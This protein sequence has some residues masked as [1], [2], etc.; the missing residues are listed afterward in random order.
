MADILSAGR[1]TMYLVNS[2]LTKRYAL[3][4]GAG[5]NLFQTN[6]KWAILFTGYTIT[7]QEI[8]SKSACLEDKRVMYSFGKGFG[9]ISITGEALLGNSKSKANFESTLKEFYESNRLS[10]NPVPLKLS[11]IGT[12]VFEFYLV[13]VNVAGYNSNYEILPFSLVGVLAK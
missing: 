11:V 1:G 6:S 8:L 7:E 10:Q 4:G 13:G 2:D 9:D 3:G 5:G 12:N